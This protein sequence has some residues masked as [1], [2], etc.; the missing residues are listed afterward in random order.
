[1]GY[2]TNFVV[3]GKPG[4]KPG[5]LH[6]VARAVDPASGRVMEVFS[7]EPGVQFYTGNFLD[8]KVKGK[9]GA[10]YGK[11]AGF[12]LETQ[13]FPDAIHHPDWPKSTSPILG[14]GEAY[15]HVMIHRFS[16]Q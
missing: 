8:G 6:S 16:T 10:V 9:G 2:D 7:S 1:M 11:H 5:E 15:H 12:C 13:K 14:S 3:S 4:E